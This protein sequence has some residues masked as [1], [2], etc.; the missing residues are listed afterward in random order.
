LTRLVFDVIGRE[1]S[2]LV[3]EQLSPGRYEVILMQ[4]ILQAEC[5][6]QIETESFT[7]TKKMLL[8]K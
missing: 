5:I 7:D 8:I 6:L 3:N 1:V 2:V 4:A